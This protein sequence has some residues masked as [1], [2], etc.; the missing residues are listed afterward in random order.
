M[1]RDELRAV[2]QWCLD[3]HLMILTK[4]NYPKIHPTYESNHIEESITSGMLRKLKKYLENPEREVFEDQGRDF[5]IDS[6]KKD[7]FA[8]SDSYTLSE[9]LSELNK[10]GRQKNVFALTPE[11]LLEK[12][13]NLGLVEVAKEDGNR[14]LSVSQLGVEKGIVLG[15]MTL[16]FPR[17]VQ[18][19][20]LNSYLIG[21]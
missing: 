5:F 3:N 13:T 18:E 7:S 8:Y 21:Y 17:E 15:N 1:T 6:D 4:E 14:V 12:L 19:E 2:I 16:R 9:L 10:T 20:I 11:E